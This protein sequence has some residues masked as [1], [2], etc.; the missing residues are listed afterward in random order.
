MRAAA[1][2]S[3]VDLTRWPEV[4]IA[5]RAVV[6]PL[7]MAGEAPHGCKLGSRDECES[8]KKVRDAADRAA[9]AEMFEQRMA[10]ARAQPKVI[11]WE[12]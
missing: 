9:R 6:V 10:V 12:Q 4:S 1:Q 11:E 3:D 8:C 7:P 5:T 2:Q